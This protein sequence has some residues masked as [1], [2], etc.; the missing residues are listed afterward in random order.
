VFQ[1]F[2]FPL[3]NLEKQFSRIGT[4]TAQPEVLTLNGTILE[5]KAFEH[6]R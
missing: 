3:E 5:R 4:I 1:Y 2:P 6:F